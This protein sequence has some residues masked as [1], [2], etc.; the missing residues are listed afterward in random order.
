MKNLFKLLNTQ[1]VYEIKRVYIV[2]VQIVVMILIFTEMH[3]LFKSYS[4]IF[5]IELFYIAFCVV[6]IIRIIYDE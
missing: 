1:D 2:I 3:S 4:V 6:M 5:I